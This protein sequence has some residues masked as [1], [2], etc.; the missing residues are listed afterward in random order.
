VV[1]VFVVADNGA[2]QMPV[3]VAMVTHVKFRR[4]RKGR[5][6]GPL[7]EKSFGEF[8]ISRGLIPGFWRGVAVWFSGR[9]MGLNPTVVA[10]F[11]VGGSEKR[12]R[13]AGDCVAAPLEISA[14]RL[15]GL[16][17]LRT[18]ASNAGTIAVLAAYSASSL[19][20]H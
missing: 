9:R 6:V 12:P 13:G 14:D 4:F 1:K 10:G 2:V 7:L 16:F 5:R 17:M 19:R 18:I 11:A 15:A 3:A 8:S 20:P